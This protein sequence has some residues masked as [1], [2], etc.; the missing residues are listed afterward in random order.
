MEW[1]GRQALFLHLNLIIIK[2][3]ADSPIMFNFIIGQ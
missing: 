1:D 3:K 2:F